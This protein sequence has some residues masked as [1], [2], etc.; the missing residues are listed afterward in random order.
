MDDFRDTDPSTVPDSSLDSGYPYLVGVL[1]GVVSDEQLEHAL[2]VCHD[3][4]HRGRWIADALS[5]LHRASLGRLGVC[6]HCQGSGR[7]P[8]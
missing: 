2:A 4:A 6:P 8:R 3:N 7:S 1:L 5:I